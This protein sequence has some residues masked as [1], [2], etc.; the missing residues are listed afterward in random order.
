M[1]DFHLLVD[2]PLAGRATFKVKG[3]KRPRPVVTVDGEG[4]ISHAGSYLLVELADR[5]GLT[6]ALSRELACLQRRRRAHD[7][8]EVLRDLAVSIAD[9]GDCLSDLTVLHHQPD[10]F[11]E[12]ASIPTAWRVIDALATALDLVPVRQARAQARA[13]AW[14]HGVRPEHITLDF[15]A[16]L[17]T[18]HSEKQG[19]AGTYKRGFGFHPLLCSLDETDEILAGL[20]RPGN[21]GANHAG[22]HIRVLDAALEQLPPRAENDPPMLARADSAGATH[23]FL[24]ALRERGVLFSVGF[25]LT[26]PVRDAVLAISPDAWVPAITQDG[27]PRDGAAVCELHDLDLSAWPTAARAICR[28]ER[29]HPGAQLSFTD[30]DGFRFQVFITDQA[31]TDLAALEARHRGHARVE[32]R[33]RCGKASGLRNLPFRDFAANEVWL[34][35][36]LVAQDLVA[37]TQRLCLDGEAAQWE[38][39][40]L[41]YCLLHVAARLV[42]SGRRLY[43]RLQCRWPWTRLLGSAFERLRSLPAA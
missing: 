40:R 20:L 14:R 1:R 34:E 6:A 26:E 10:L 11:G 31:D 2:R 23:D 36:V 29:P 33:I 5:V 42:R 39:K 30:H 25:D 15:D 28:R 16:T 9:G 43:L 32:D 35:L 22:D 19:A 41:R 18:A 8:G 37:W 21:A 3:T 17:V 12:V 24:D 4:V 7:P 27:D 38:P 13:H